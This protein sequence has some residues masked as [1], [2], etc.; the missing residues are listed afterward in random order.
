LDRAIS[1]SSFDKLEKMEKTEGFGESV[2]NNKTGEIKKFFYLGPKNNWNDILDK[3]IAEEIS[4]K[5]NSEM[6]ELGYL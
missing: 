2:I 6:K 3:K 5:F 4:F 1:A